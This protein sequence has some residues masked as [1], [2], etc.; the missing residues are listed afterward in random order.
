MNKLAQEAVL[1]S[2]TKRLHD[3]GSWAGETHLQKAAYLLKDL[4]EVPFDFTFIL[5][6]H[7]PFSFELRDELSAMRGDE[8]VDRKPQLPPY[9][10]RI[11]ANPNG[12][13]LA[14]QFQKTMA[15]Y[16]PRVDWIAS[17]LGDRGVAELERLATALWVTRELG[18]EATVQERALALNKVKNHVSVE[19]AAGA[20]EEI[21]RLLADSA[22]LVASSN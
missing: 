15:R 13:A 4:L 2:L 20:V 11:V 21:D 9:G 17:R 16:G 14:E 7:G 10:P 8:L 19:A 12:L 18:A 1:V 22:E 5:Y 6:K 3:E